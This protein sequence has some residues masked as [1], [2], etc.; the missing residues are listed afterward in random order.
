MAKKKDK[1]E[2]SAESVL[3]TA[4]KNIGAPAGKIAA[5]VGVTPEERPQTKSAKVPKLASKNKSR[6]P[7]RQK[8]AQQKSATMK[9]K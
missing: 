8:K 6:L 4:A 7:R 3:L 1:Q 9:K 2:E 5:A